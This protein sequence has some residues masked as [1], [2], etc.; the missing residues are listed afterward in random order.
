MWTTDNDH[1]AQLQFHTGRHALEGHFPTIGSWVHYGLGSLNDNLPQFVVLGTP[2]ADCCGGMDGH[3]ADYLGPEHA[4]VRLDVDPKNP[5]PF[6]A[7]G[8]GRLPRGAAGASSSC[9]GELNRLVG[10]RVSR[11]PGAAGPDQVVRAGLPHADGRARGAAASTTKTDATQQLY[12]LDK[13]TTPAVRPAVPGR[14]AAGRARRAVRAGL[15]RQQRRRRRLGRPRRPQGQPHAALRA[16]RSADRRPAQGPQAARPARRD[17]RRLGHRVRPHARRAGRRRPR[18]SP[19]RLLASGW[20]A[21]ASRAAS[22][23][24]RPTSS[25][26]TP[27]RTATTSPT[28]TPPSCTSSASTR[29]G[30][31]S[32]AASGWRSTTASRSAR[33]S[34]SRLGRPHVSSRGNPAFPGLS[35]R[36]IARWPS[37]R[38]EG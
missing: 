24:A 19:L 31:K 9:C 7:P 16:G 23:T 1:G 13:P 38:R 14:P 6:A 22:S 35:S 10:G 5:L 18:P 8:A 21:A 25:A 17:A 30:W 20:P 26:S 33:S 34:P 12:G 36:V 32:P 3:G 27:S 4:G 11:R 37:R 2:L 28:S 29:A 15:P